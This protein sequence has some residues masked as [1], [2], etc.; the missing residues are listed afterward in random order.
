MGNAL[1]QWSITLFAL[2]IIGAE[3][4]ARAD[5]FPNGCSLL[6]L[7]E[8]SETTLQSTK[9]LQRIF[10]ESYEPYLWARMGKEDF[11][12]Y[13]RLIEEK[14]WSVRASAHPIEIYGEDTW[15]SF[16]E[17][18]FYLSSIPDGKFSLSVDLIRETHRLITKNIFK[19]LSKLHF[20]GL[21]KTIF[22]QGGVLKKANNYGFWSLFHNL[23]EKE[24]HGLKSNPYVEFKE[25]PF[26]ISREGKRRGLIVYTHADDL[27]KSL[28]DLC[29]WT[30]SALKTRD[31]L[32]VAAIFQRRF[33]SLHP[34][35]D[36]NGRTS[37]IIMDRIL[38]EKG[39]APPILLD[40]NLDLYS[41]EVDWIQSVR[42][43]ARRTTQYLEKKQIAAMNA[44]IQP[45][46]LHVT[47]YFFPPTQPTPRHLI[48][49]GGMK[50]LS[51]KEGTLLTN[52]FGQVYVLIGK[53]LTPIS[54][55][56]YLF[57][58][59]SLYWPDS[60]WSIAKSRTKRW[61]AEHKANPA[62]ASSIEVVPYPETRM[63]DAMN[64]FRIP[65]EFS[66]DFDRSPLFREPKDLNEALTIFPRLK[67]TTF[68][69]SADSLKQLY[70]ANAHIDPRY[71]KSFRSS[72][73]RYLAQYQ[74]VNL[75]L[76]DLIRDL[77]PQ[78]PGHAAKLRSRREI[79]EASLMRYVKSIRA[80][81]NRLP[82]KDQAAL[83][84]HPMVRTTLTY[85]KYSP[86]AKAFFGK[87][88]VHDLDRAVYLLR[89][90]SASIGQLGIYSDAEIHK[91][92]GIIPGARALAE[93][94]LAD[95]NK[96]GEGWNSIL[97][98]LGGDEK[99][100]FLEKLF[101]NTSVIDV[102]RS[103]TYSRYNG[104][105]A[106]IEFKRKFVDFYFHSESSAGSDYISLSGNL[107]LYT[108]GIL[109]TSFNF[110][111]DPNAALYLVRIPKGEALYNSFSTFPEEYEILSR[112][113]ILP[114]AIREK[115][116]LD[117]EVAEKLKAFKANIGK[118]GR[119]FYERYFEPPFE[120]DD[121]FAF[122]GRYPE[123]APRTGTI[124]GFPPPVPYPGGVIEDGFGTNPAHTNGPPIGPV[125]GKPQKPE[126]PL[127]PG[128][129]P[130][131]PPFPKPG[132]VHDPKV[133]ITPN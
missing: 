111:Q 133:I 90:D 82:P 37:R 80:E 83:E 44:E 99:K 25:L 46:S 114:S 65:P 104:R 81:W 55:R 10:S 122:P 30:N 89:S 94:I 66:A 49:V 62:V 34:F 38:R 130:D 14:D 78:Y 50:F 20:A 87:E 15:L 4:L 77:G 57:L 71:L 24:F 106:E 117:P 53:K 75:E 59:G 23:S 40:H 36:G 21:P 72:L 27:E 63:A 96:F 32:E 86:F 108:Q 31:P 7:P 126:N 115:I 42:E 28:N 112:D 84:E 91:L 103:S 131:F 100:T 79:A 48:E 129:Y 119:E 107:E 120:P 2:V 124:D 132:E 39:I 11:L 109:G 110:S 47:N 6:L 118:T 56:T 123:G 101:G 74:K 35:Q 70:K 58:E 113:K 26:P 9:E 52:R 43:G 85:L 29:E 16:R 3:H 73:N 1:K 12:D 17:A 92:F 116:K 68:E 5:E 13:R 125:P 19:G 54:D 128:A 41:S 93:K 33:T 127:P 67:Q 98:R 102:L 45:P 8:K 61:L 22:K 105:S 121:G 69:S 64:A 76:D 51:A 18:D 97:N 60:A 88:F 95:P